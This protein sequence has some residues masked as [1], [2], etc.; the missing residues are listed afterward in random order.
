MGDICVAIK[1]GHLIQN[2]FLQK[3]LQKLMFEDISIFLDT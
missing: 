3:H 2:L 1:R